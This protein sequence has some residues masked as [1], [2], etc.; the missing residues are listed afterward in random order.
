MYQDALQDA[1]H[2]LGNGMQSQM[3]PIHVA[4]CFLTLLTIM[5]ETPSAVNI[6]I[7]M[8]AAQTTISRV[9]CGAA[10]Q[11]LGRHTR[12]L[13]RLQGKTV[14]AS[15]PTGTAEALWLGQS[16]LRCHVSGAVGAQGCS[17]L[18]EGEGKQRGRVRD[19]Q[20]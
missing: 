15:L 6:S 16:C 2:L 4:Q 17:E 19:C 11:L 13:Q 1:R 18:R 9:T 3:Q 20:Q 12:A 7:T 10:S 5:A 14:R 8:H